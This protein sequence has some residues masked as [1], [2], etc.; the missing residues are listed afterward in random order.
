MRRTK[1]ESPYP[2]HENTVESR[3]FR[4]EDARDNRPNFEELRP[5]RF[6]G[7]QVIMLLVNLLMI[8]K[9]LLPVIRLEPQKVFTE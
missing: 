3:G 7:R 8:K 2:S 4:D 9:I 5:E 6:G 1:Y